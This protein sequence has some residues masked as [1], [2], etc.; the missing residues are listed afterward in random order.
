MPGWGWPRTRVDDPTLRRLC[1]VLFGTLGGDGRGRMPEEIIRW[2][3]QGVERIVQLTPG[4]TLSQ[5][6]RRAMLAQIEIDG[7]T[8]TPLIPK[9]TPKSLPLV[10]EN[11]LSRARVTRDEDGCYFPAKR[12]T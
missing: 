7:G 2:Q 4:L 8:P 11:R 1:R 3:V 5:I 10:V 12:D 9:V 6:A